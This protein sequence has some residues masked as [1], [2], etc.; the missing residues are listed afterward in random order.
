M[1]SARLH[2]F[3]RISKRGCS[4]SR[5]QIFL[6]AHDSNTISTIQEREYH[7]IST[8]VTQ[9]AN[10][11][12]VITSNDIS[13]MDNAH[14]DMDFFG[15]PLTFFKTGRTENKPTDK[16]FSVEDTIF[17]FDTFVSQYITRGK[18]SNDGGNEHGLSAQAA[19]STAIPWS[20][21]LLNLMRLCYIENDKW[22]CEAPML[23]CAAISPILALG[24]SAYLKLLDESYLLNMKPSFTDMAQ[25]AVSTLDNEHALGVL[26]VREKYHLQALQFLLQNEHNKA[27]SSLRKLLELC[28]GDALGLSLAMDIASSIG[29]KRN[30]FYA[31]T[32]VASYWSERGNLSAVG[33]TAIPGFALGSS[34]IALG[35][36][37]GGRFREAEQLIDIAL[38]RD[39]RDASGI[40]AWALAHI[41]DCEGRVSEGA[42]VFTGYGTEYYVSCG[43]MFFDAML[44]GTG[45][46]FI[47]D[48]D[49]ASS[50]N[51]AKR[52]YDEHFGRILSYSGYSE[53][54]LGPILNSKPKS[55]KMIIAESAVSAAS[56]AFRNL[57]GQKH[58]EPEEESK[59]DRKSSNPL[60]LEDILTWLP[61]TPQVLTEATF[62]LSRLTL[63][64]S[65]NMDDERWSQLRCAWRKTVDNELKY[66]T[67]KKLFD[68]FPLARIASSLVLGDS[69]SF[70]EDERESIELMM[71]TM[72]LLLKSNQPKNEDNKKQWSNVAMKLSFFRSG[73]REEECVGWNQNF[74][75]FLEHSI[76]FAANE[77]DDY[78]TLCMARSVCSESVA[79]RPNSPE[80]W[81]RYG[82]ILEKLGDEE[83]AR[84]AFDAS[85]SLGA[86]EGASVHAT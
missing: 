8:K 3:R 86:G 32:S 23:A 14:Q 53:S 11:D 10:V 64:G 45:G 40:C 27:L 82:V 44:G 55:T 52:M 6:W 78:E 75:N 28:P 31:A 49:G 16:S 84:N 63:S 33:Q 56:S 43:F 60:S 50:D 1:R 24:G 47:L 35:L 77:S 72:G 85:V 71:S 73:R 7:N 66:E 4:L 76:C 21:L 51:V 46:R 38:S 58:V 67:E 41:Y 59:S 68:H 2:H 48:R 19:H 9:K 80:T 39:K 13:G 79:L 29:D 30:A 37:V 34:L 65:I 62:L 5:Y 81:F 22:K 15:E 42:S 74:G 57:F 61:P 70:K 54:N 12:H 20:D 17:S 69:S 26:S 25:A 18:S 83:S 36:A